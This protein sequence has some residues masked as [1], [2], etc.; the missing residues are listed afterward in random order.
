MTQGTGGVGTIPYLPPDVL[1][2][3]LSSLPPVFPDA[4][5]ARNQALNNVQVF[6]EVRDIERNVLVAISQGIFEINVTNTFMTS[7]PQAPDYYMAWQN[8]TNRDLLLQMKQVLKYFEEKNY[9]IQRKTNE[10]TLNTFFWR[11]AW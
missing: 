8:D 11:L 1:P 10:T 9:I 3:S 7:G 5:T 4:Q 6:D 2:N